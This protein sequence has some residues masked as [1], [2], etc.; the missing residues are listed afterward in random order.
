MSFP[1]RDTLHLQLEEV[2]DLKSRF[3]KLPPRARFEVTTSTGARID[4]GKYHY[5]HNYNLL[6]EGGLEYPRW[7]WQGDTL[8]VKIV[9]V[10][11]G[12]KRELG[13]IILGPDAWAN[14]D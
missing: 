12:K 2:R 8:T 5:G 6:K 9:E 4:R 3:Y 11:F 14:T 1:S 13:H 10:L 7:N